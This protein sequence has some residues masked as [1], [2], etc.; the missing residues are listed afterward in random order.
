MAAVEGA[1]SG[2]AA[3]APAGPAGIV[4]GAIIGGISSYVT[5][6]SAAKSAEKG[7]KIAAEA[8]L[9]ATQMQL[10]E[11]RRQ[12]D[13]Q[14][15]V[16]MPRLQQQY[17]AAGAFSD[18]LGIGNNNQ[19]GSST[20]SASVAPRPA[21]SST[22]AP[23]GPGPGAPGQATTP[24]LPPP[25]TPTGGSNYVG[26][27]RTGPAAGVGGGTNYVGGPRTGPA[28]NAVTQQQQ[29]AQAGPQ[30][31]QTVPTWYPPGVSPGPSDLTPPTPPPP[32]STNFARDPDAG[33]FIDPNVNPRSQEALARSNEIYGPEFTESPGYA[34]QVE[35]M[36][37]EL[38]RGRSAGGNYGGRAIMEGQRRAGGL[39][40]GEF[41][42]YAAGRER[43]V[44]RI[45]QGAARDIGRDDQSYQNYLSNLRA[46]AGFGDVAGQAVS[47]SAATAG[48][49]SSAIGA[50][51]AQRSTI[52]NTLGGTQADIATSTGTNINNAITAGMQ[53][54]AT[55]YNRGQPPTDEAFSLYGD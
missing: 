44:G 50:G 28:S 54:L 26:G 19:V 36:N 38:E 7:A 43:E 2:A 21:I 46:M 39:A 32:G 40:A 11:I 5:G 51:G 42:N 24:G 13:Y 47:S 17:A 49:A 33:F 9:Q 41:Y 48:A 37:R 53:G 1:A 31:P 29:Y 15:A 30:A 45:E 25:T 35:E 12:F 23:V 6:K 8:S 18:L 14:Q 20:F 55:Y 34:F 3:G 10:E 22:G 27:P 52:F 16:L 4:A